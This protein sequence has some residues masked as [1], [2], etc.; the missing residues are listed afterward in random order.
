[1]I[2]KENVA[3]ETEQFFEDDGSIVRTEAQ[4]EHIFQQ[5]GLTLRQTLPENGYP[6][7][8]VPVKTFILTAK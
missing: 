1:M 4:F 3:R 6:K 7:D 8:L 5:A 2:V